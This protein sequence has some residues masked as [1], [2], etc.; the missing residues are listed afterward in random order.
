MIS[1][2]QVR[3]TTKYKKTHLKRVPFEMKKDFYE[4]VL[5]PAVEKSGQSTNGY[6]KEAILRRIKEDESCGL[7]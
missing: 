7:S 1:E 4:E 6:I 3:A 5:K 2:A